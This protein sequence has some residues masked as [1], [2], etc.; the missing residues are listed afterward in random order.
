M[1]NVRLLLTSVIAIFVVIPAVAEPNHTSDTFPVDEYML[2]DYTYTGAA[3][4]ENMG[5]YGG[6]IVANPEYNWINYNINAGEYLAAGATSAS[7]CTAG[8]FCTGINNIN[9][10]EDNDQ[11]LTACS[12][13]DGGAYP[14]SDIGASANTDCYRACTTANVPHSASVSGNDYYGAGTDTCAATACENGYSVKEGTPDLI[15]LI[16]T[17]AG[18]NYTYD[19]NTMTFS[20]VFNGKGTLTG[21]S[22]C[23]TQYGNSVVDGNGNVMTSATLPD[24]VGSN[25]YCQLNGWTPYGGEQTPLSTPWV[26]YFDRFEAADCASYCAFDCAFHLMDNFQGSLAFR[27]AVFGTLS[28]EPATCAANTITI[29][30]GAASD[31]DIAANDAATVTYDSDIRTPRAVPQIP[32]YRFKGWK[33]NKPQL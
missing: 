21:K 31:E 11:G 12:T 8:N 6:D 5:I 18:N 1:K 27:S 16:G 3:T 22:Q 14:N 23:S 15:T 25:C 32:G 10:D 4:Y 19:S 28:S 17:V 26:F 7:A 13:L 9:Y 30:W 33:F 2:E 20:V 24:N 29:N